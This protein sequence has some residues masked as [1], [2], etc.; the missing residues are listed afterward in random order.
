M[1]DGFGKTKYK[2]GSMYEGYY[3]KNKKHGK[4]KYTFSDGHQ[5][6]NGEWKNNKRHGHGL[7]LYKSGDIY[8]G[9]FVNNMREGQGTIMIKETG[10]VYQGTWLADK[11]HGSGFCIVEN[12]ENTMVEKKKGWFKKLF[13][14]KNV[15]QV[16]V[17]FDNNSLQSSKAMKLKPRKKN[18]DEVSLPEELRRVKLEE[19]QSITTMGNNSALNF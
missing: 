18:S 3:R 7:R 19:E 1:I 17:E 8:E 5:Y 11:M 13:S 2:N 9:G 4:G 15:K 6:Y 14:K 16:K 10:I 12:N